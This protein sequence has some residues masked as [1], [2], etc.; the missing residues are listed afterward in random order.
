[1]EARRVLARFACACAL[2][3]LTR[4][5]SAEGDPEK[6]A[7]GESYA[8]RLSYEV[9]AGC[10]TA[11]AFSDAVTANSTR[12]H[13]ASPDETATDIDAL[14]SL[15]EGGF[16]GMLRIRR[17]DGTESTRSVPAPTCTETVSAMAFIAAI[18]IDPDAAS[19]ASIDE[20]PSDGGPSP[21]PN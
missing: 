6:S 1:M 3:S 15:R 17:P 19:R 5:A 11:E 13:R 18:T 21:L 8:F 9:P 4:Q 12:V 7:K 16:L 14:A 10:P 20:L 2:A